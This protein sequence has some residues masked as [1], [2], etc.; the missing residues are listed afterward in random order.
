[1]NLNEFWPKCLQRLQCSLSV[2]QYQMWIAPLTVAE[3]ADA[4][5]VYAKTQFVL[6]QVKK[7]FW[8]EIEALKTELATDAPALTLTIG[9][10]AHLQ[11]AAAAPSTV[12]PDAEAAAG[13]E[14]ALDIVQ[15]YV[16]ADASVP[17]PAAS[18][19]S[20][21]AMDKGKARPAHN[22]QA[23]FTFD[24]LVVGKGNEVAV[25]VARNI[26][27]Q[28]GG[29]YNPFYLYSSPGLGKTHLVQAI[30]HALLQAHPQAKVAYM[31]ADDYVRSL[32]NA[33]K[34]QAFDAFKQQ[35]KPYDLL[36]LD[37]VQFIAGKERTMEEFFY[38][39]NHFQKEKKQLILTGDKLPNDIDEMDV[40]LKTRFNSGLSLRL[41]PPELEMRVAI[42]QKKAELAGARL[43]EAA[44]FFIA[45][46]IKGSVRDLEGAF[47][48]VDA[49]SRFTGRAIDTELVREALQD[50][51]ASSHRVMTAEGIMETVSK[52][53]G[54][55]V[56]DLTGKKR[57]RNI[58]RPRQMAM[59]LMKDLTALSLPAIGH[60][61]DRNHTTVMHAVSTIADLRQEEAQ[62]E[63][64]YQKLL[65]LIKS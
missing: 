34:K 1:M 55:S 30:G 6:T 29:D 32:M 50:I 36:I 23:E 18:L 51:V 37:D 54:V 24:T 14:S 56:N 42:L 10:G 26:A 31:H 4:W 45:K 17:P 52:Y 53:Y 7:Q 62:I 3:T 40:R 25:A 16:R 38:L 64:D 8:A 65:I 27:E 58:A 49:R 5:L 2:R 20:K 13:R 47:K 28:P 33:A 61:F 39:F 46:H 60:C 44:A 43:D 12:A 11:A 41:E 35:Y 19:P 63:Q 59:A 15:K 21:D 22:L 57:A 48:R 9:E